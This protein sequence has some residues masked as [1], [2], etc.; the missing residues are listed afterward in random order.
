MSSQA[1]PNPS[2]RR[3]PG[4]TSTAVVTMQTVMPQT[5]TVSPHKFDTYPS[6]T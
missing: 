2:E 4:F 3:V 1:V 5:E 6:V